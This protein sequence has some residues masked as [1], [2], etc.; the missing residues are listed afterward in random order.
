MEIYFISYAI[1][2]FAAF[3]RQATQSLFSTKSH[4]FLLLLLLLFLL[5]LLLL[6]SNSTFLNHAQKFKFWPGYI[7]VRLSPVIN[8]DLLAVLRDHIK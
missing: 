8:S 3:L 2:T 1:K 6:S 4:L 7:K 5:L